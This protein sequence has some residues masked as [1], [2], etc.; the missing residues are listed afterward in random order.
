ME[1]RSAT[2]RE[3]KDEKIQAATLS[4]QNCKRYLKEFN[5]CWKVSETFKRFHKNQITL[6]YIM[7]HWATAD[8]SFDYIIPTRHPDLFIFF[9]TNSS[10]KLN[11]TMNKQDI[12]SYFEVALP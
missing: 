12:C 5:V 1:Q 10:D 3:R 2:N 11:E 7:F 6:S 9:G 8:K 4:K